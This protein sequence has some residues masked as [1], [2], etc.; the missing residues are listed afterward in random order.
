MKTIMTWL[1]NFWRANVDVVAG[2]NAFDMPKRTRIVVAVG[3]VLLCLLLDSWISTRLQ[4]VAASNPVEGS[5]AWDATLVMRVA[6]AREWVVAKAIVL[7]LLGGYLGFG[8]F[9]RTPLGKRLWHWAEQ[10][11]EY[12]CAA[13]TLSATLAF[14]GILMVLAIHT[15]RMLP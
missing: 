15:S 3:F 13:K 2:N 8:L 1:K 12:T 4:A 6:A 11:T 5:A 10:D 9:D 14:I 7:T